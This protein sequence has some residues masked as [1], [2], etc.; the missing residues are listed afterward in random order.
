M[1]TFVQC[2]VIHGNIGSNCIAWA[3][4]SVASTSELP[5]QQGAVS[6]NADANAWLVVQ[7]AKRHV[8]PHLGLCISPGTPLL[9]LSPLLLFLLRLRLCSVLRASYA[10]V[11]HSQLAEASRLMQAA[12]GSSAEDPLAAAPLILSSCV[13]CRCAVTLASAA[14]L[15]RA[16][17]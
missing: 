3:A 5:Q 7:H 10:M 16:A 12:S 2:T 15:E 8:P 13:R 17:S 11:A 1:P 6:T 14:A 4:C 9:T